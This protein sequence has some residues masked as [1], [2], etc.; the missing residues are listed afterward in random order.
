MRAYYTIYECKENQ[1]LMEGNY[2]LRD[3]GYHIESIGIK[4]DVVVQHSYNP[5]DTN[6]IISVVDREMRNVLVSNPP[7]TPNPHSIKK[8]NSMSEAEDY[9]MSGAIYPQSGEF[10]SIRKIWL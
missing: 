2:W 10:Y 4:H 8:W 1:W 7:Q 9:L 5:N 6:P 3:G